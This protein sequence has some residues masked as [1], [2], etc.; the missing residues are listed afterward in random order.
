MRRT[1]EFGL[2][3]AI[4]CRFMHQN[5]RDEMRPFMIQAPPGDRQTLRVLPQ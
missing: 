2:V 3:N 5:S 4:D 1:L